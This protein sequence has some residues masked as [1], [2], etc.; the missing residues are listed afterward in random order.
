[1][2][3]SK[4]ITEREM[5]AL[6]YLSG[7]VM[8]ALVRKVYKFSDYKSKQSQEILS[9]LYAAK[10]DNVSAQ[11]IVASQT[12]GGLWSV[13]PECVQAGFLSALPYLIMTI[14][15]QIGGQLADFLRSSGRMSTTTVRKLFTAIGFMSQGLFMIIVGYST[16]KNLALFALVMAVG[17][18]GLAYSGFIINHLDIAPRYASLLFGMSNTFATIPGIVGPLVVGFVTTHEVCNSNIINIMRNSNYLDSKFL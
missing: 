15:I 14:M 8:N 2:A 18:D 9:L 4:P 3:S 16:S 6:Q 7:Y 11:R 12:R 10:N 5:D 1:M 13:T 17:F